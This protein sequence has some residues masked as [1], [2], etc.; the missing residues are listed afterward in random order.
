VSTSG[1]GADI[2]LI[3]ATVG[4]ALAAA[5]MAFTLAGPLGMR[6]PTFPTW[7]GWTFVAIGV[8]GTAIGYAA[9]EQLLRAGGSVFAMRAGG[10]LLLVTGAGLLA[11]QPWAWLLGFPVAFGGIVNGVL[12]LIRGPTRGF[13]WFALVLYGSAINA[14]WQARGRGSSLDEPV[15]STIPPPPGGMPPAPPPPRPDQPVALP[16][17]RPEMAVAAAP[18]PM[19]ATPPPPPPPPAADDPQSL[20][21]ALGGHRE[22]PSA[23]WS[24]EAKRLVELGPG[25]VPV[26]LANLR[27][28]DYV[29]LIL[30]RIGGEGVYEALVELAHRGGA[31]ETDGGFA[32][33]RAW[34][35]TQ[36]AI[37]GL[38]LLRDPRAIPLLTRIAEETNVEQLRFAAGDAIG[39]I[40]SGA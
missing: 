28:S 40:K 29:P 11:K 9:E 23:E 13:S 34:F 15:P 39:K 27:R 22:S 7:V 31:F 38:G 30:G 16:P 24:P 10:V 5:A 19:S 8:L 3:L 4:G 1:T 36:Y 20:V 18:A 26:L 25:A 37:A 2:G 17:P 21:A 14:L 32:E 12:G 35:A 33:Q 6:R